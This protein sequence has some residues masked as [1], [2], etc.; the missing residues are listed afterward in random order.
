MIGE[1]EPSDRDSHLT[2]SG[3]H[4]AAGGEGGP[5][6]FLTVLRIFTTRLW[7]FLTVV[8]IVMLLTGYI[9]WQEVRIYRA[10]TEILIERQMSN[11]RNLEGPLMV[12]TDE[13]DYYNSQVRILQG[14][15]LADRVAERLKLHQDPSFGE[16]A[17]SAIIDG[18][19]VEFIRNSRIFA[20]SFEHADPQ[21][22][23]L[24]A[25]TIVDE[26]K[27]LTV[28]RRIQTIRALGEEMLT[29]LEQ[30]KADL[31]RSEADL[32]D[33]YGQHG[34]LLGDERG[35][36]MQRLADEAALQL[37]HEEK[38]LL[39]AESLAKPIEEA[40][41]DVKR[42]R[43]V[44]L[45]QGAVLDDDFFVQE[46]Q[47]YEQLAELARAK[48]ADHPAYLA[49][50][51]RAEEMS[52]RVDDQVGTYA[53][54][55]LIRRD[56]L[57]DSV[58]KLRDRFEDIRRQR[59]EQDKLIARADVL[60]RNRDANR[61]L[62][63]TLTLRI[64]ESRISSGLETANIHVL[65]VAKPSKVPV[66]PNITLN[67]MLG[68][69]IAFVVG[70]VTTLLL[71]RIDNTVRTLED[72]EERYNLP[73]LS[74]VP[75][76]KPAE[77]KG[78]PALVC[79]NAE[80]SQM[81]EAFRRVRAGVLL[82]VRKGEGGPLRSIMICSA[83]PGEGKTVTAS[84]L[85]ISLAQMGERTLLIDTD[86]YRSETHNAFGLECDRGLSTILTSDIPLAQAVQPTLV[87][88]L[89][90]LA[91]G[92]APPQA[93]TLLGSPRMKWLL[94]EAMRAYSRVVID[95]SPLVAVTDGTLIAPHVDAHVLVLSEGKTLKTALRRSLQTLARIN[96]WPMGF[97]F[98]GV[99]AG[100]GEFYF[101]YQNPTY[102]LEEDVAKTVGQNQ[103]N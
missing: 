45:A 102:Q 57:R 25:N 18:L 16:E 92:M 54:S 43:A 59:L 32:A 24:V 89:D 95:T 81:A 23:A 27:K 12:N 103:A 49:A 94:G 53:A 60:R 33:F 97:V 58:R 22:A 78:P 38:E 39:R 34:L 69:V 73:V 31:T 62:Y 47:A 11:L 36:T 61:S 17:G 68:L 84:N 1:P 76:G 70:A 6:F 4:A 5:L 91:T 100:V 35:T 98:N 96:V 51:A 72:V 79:W 87:P 93:A 20:I 48:Q 19:S 2:S 101:K 63:D 26:Y 29:E 50:K 88:A 9:T 10:S 42:L 14:Q 99:K 8:V 86:F 83:G 71:D 66:H 64:K 67:L 46:A 21:L 74:V 15:G 44:V 41:G 30:V 28:E 52:R 40:G 77:L 7:A 65:K 56:A 13:V 82:S 90:F 37:F 80:R 3:T 85:A 55:Q 75:H